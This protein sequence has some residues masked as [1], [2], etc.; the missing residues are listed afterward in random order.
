MPSWL[1]GLLSAI[2]AASVVTGGI[3]WL[4]EPRIE[5]YVIT[6]AEKSETIKQLRIEQEQTRKE[7]QDTRKALQENNK[8]L[9]ELKQQRRDR[10]Q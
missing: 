7:L 4:S 6:A 2:P 1:G 3:L 10:P 8:L 5:E 9:R